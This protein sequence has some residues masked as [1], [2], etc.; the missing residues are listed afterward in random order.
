VY[1]ALV[2]SLFLPRALP[3]GEEDLLWSTLLGGNDYDLGYD[4][5]V[6]RDGCVYLTGV[7][8][9]EDF[10]RSSG[11][12]DTL[13]GGRD[14]LVAKFFPGGDSLAYT[15]ILGGTGDD[16]GHGIEVDEDGFV[17]VAGVT[18]SDDFPVTPWAYDTSASGAR[19]AA[20]LKLDPSGTLL[21]YSTYIGGGGSESARAVAVD[22]E[23]RAWL[24][25][26]T[27]SG[28]FP[29]T[30]GAFDTSY[31]GGHWDAYVAGLSLHGDKLLYGSLLGGEETEEGRDIAL[32][33]R[34]RVLVTGQTGSDDFPVTLEVHDYVH[35][36]GRDAFVVK[37]DTTGSRLVFGTYLGG[38]LAD[39]TSGIAVGGDDAIYVTGKT[40]SPDFPTTPGAYDRTQHG[41]Y[42]ADAFVTRFSPA[43]ES[44]SFST[45]LGGANIDEAQGIALTPGGEIFVAGWT[46]SADF[47]GTPGSFCPSHSGRYSD[48]FL[49]G[50][51]ST[52]GQLTYGTF[53]G[54][55]GID[56]AWGLASDREGTLYLVGETK[57]TDYPT[58][59]GAY[60]DT[61][62]GDYADIFVSSL[63]PGATPVT[64]ASITDVG[65]R[66][67]ALMHS[68]P[69]PFNAGTRIRYRI[70]TPGRVAVRIFNTRGQLVLTLADGYRFSGDYTVDWDGVDAAGRRV[71]S[72][73]Y[74]CRLQARSAGETLKL[75]LL[76]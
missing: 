25:G 10:P 6:G 18:D 55:N 40:F 9:S 73:I 68:W 21:Y 2:F 11:P 74:F 45:Y 17:Y 69:N 72:G 52:G 43:A 59:A 64:P 54:G 50:L 75:V 60:C 63:R 28:D 36:G 23:G 38:S 5:A 35:N 13:H 71:A 46:H 53:L 7:V 26:D 15:A 48:A 24:T 67:Y 27:E 31:N 4:I 41:M 1:I 51:D 39:Q 12:A 70:S 76:R 61:L 3:A 19:D 33:S 65:P 29:T 47:P 66:S 14:I 49:A 58:T 8:T 20:A 42:A 62:T 44:L 37:L 56:L 57:S 30:P 16:E 32:D 22:D 34:G